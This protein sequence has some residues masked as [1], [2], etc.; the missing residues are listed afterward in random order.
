MSSKL[1]AFN[2]S[3]KTEKSSEETRN[4]WIGDQTALAC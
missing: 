4:Q 3:K 1:F 2:M